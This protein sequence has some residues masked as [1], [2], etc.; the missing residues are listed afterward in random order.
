MM[1]KLHATARC[2]IIGLIIFICIFLLAEKIQYNETNNELQIKLSRMVI[3]LNER[4]RNT[5]ISAAQGLTRSPVLQAR[6]RNEISS[7]DPT[8][9]ETLQTARLLTH[10]S[11]ADAVNKD[12]IIVAMAD[13]LSRPSILNTDVSFRPYFQAA[14][15][16]KNS[17]YPASG[18]RSGK[19]LL[20]FSAP[21]YD[22]TTKEFLGIT[23]LNIVGESLDNF[24]DSLATP[25]ALVSPDGVIFASNRPDWVMH[26]LWPLD[27]ST[28]SRIEKTRQ[29]GHLLPALFPDIPHA[30]PL[31]YKEKSWIPVSVPLDW[32]GGW[33]LFSL[34][35]KQFPFLLFFQLTAGVLVFGLFI[36]TT[37]T[38]ILRK[39]KES[40]RK[41]SERQ[42]YDVFQHSSDP[43]ILVHNDHFIDANDAAIKLLG[44]KDKAPLLSLTPADIS[45]PIQPDGSSSKE[46]FHR[47]IKL[48]L[49]KGTHQFE[50]MHVRADGESILVNVTLTSMLFDDK[51]IIHGVWKDVTDLRKAQKELERTQRQMQGI[52]D[53]IQSMVSIR[54]RSGHYLLVN[55]FFEELV[56]VSNAEIQGKTPY[57]ILSKDQADAVL[58]DDALVL[59]SGKP[60]VREGTVYH[61]DN[62]RTWLTTKTPLYDV[63]GQIYAVCSLYIDISKRI[64]IENRL[65][66]ERQFLQTLVNSVP[67]PIVYVDHDEIIRLLNTAF[68]DLI[69]K[70]RESVLEQPFSLV[71][72]EQAQHIAIHSNGSSL[73]DQDQTTP[74]RF[75]APKGSSRYFLFHKAAFKQE[76]EDNPGCIIVFL[77]VTDIVAARQRAE[78][79]ASKL[80]TTLSTSED[81]RSKADDALEQAK[82][83]AEEADRASRAKS[84]FLA[85]MSHEIR[86]PLNVIVGMTDLTLKKKL[87]ED[88][89]ENLDIVRSAAGHLLQIVNDVLDIAKIEAGRLELVG[90]DFSPTELCNAVI[91]MFRL[92]A[93]RKGLKLNL[94]IAPDVPSHVFG[95]AARVRQVLVNLVGNAV[96]FTEKGHVRVFLEHHDV[97]QTQYGRYIGLCFKVEDTG[98]GIAEED[99]QTVFETFRQLGGSLTR[100]Y[101]GTG[102]GLAISRHLAEHMGGHIK[103][104]S[105]FNTGS[106]FIF[107][108]LFEPSKSSPLLV[109]TPVESQKSPHQS[110]SILLVEDNAF[111]ALLARKIF[112]Q[113]GHSDVIVAK[114]GHEALDILSNTPFNIIF[115]DLEMPGID[116]IEVTRQLRAGRAGSMNQDTP[117]VAMTAHVVKEI[118]LRCEAAGMNGFLP[119][120]VNNARLGAILTDY[121]AK[122]DSS[123]PPQPASDV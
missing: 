114:N 75:P 44:Y 47:I 5:Y 98:I 2:A 28:L 62:S 85:S 11:S 51:E 102:L 39:R 48:S 115:M 56:D 7:D 6:L 79:M 54:D 33:S 45:P 13:A 77:D 101:E 60:F 84:E 50:W 109:S 93:E 25:S 120:P 108:A 76:Y 82:R 100:Q 19:R 99:Q 23:V 53:T 18:I 107:T 9:I 112:D 1:P 118:K 63:N 121:A 22:N 68:I 81:L 4:L 105:Q 78:D 12:G 64:E 72:P 95:D 20:F 88:V 58:A 74:L 21:V 111:N 43:I 119:K 3:G 15:K 52:L 41:Q 16:G 46:K 89:A 65:R 34:A 69:D 10:A 80:S 92:Q 116:G 122:T 29:F 31:Y 67:S 8:L 73:S 14:L 103:L 104:S 110:L 123:S 90:Q 36:T 26:S 27:K 17:L 94:S 113:L 61:D 37:F 87:H 106:T 55:R 40:R 71:L 30:A 59:S 66:R 35:P 57:D 96:K 49:D 91:D 42:F 97:P 86:T 117:I 24:L 70:P 83:F 38:L 32:T